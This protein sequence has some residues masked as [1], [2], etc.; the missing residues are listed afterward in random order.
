MATLSS[1]DM[2]SLEQ[3][4][5]VTTLSVTLSTEEIT[6]ITSLVTELNVKLALITQSMAFSKAAFI[7]ITTIEVTEIQ[8]LSGKL[9]GVVDDVVSD[10]IASLM[11]VS[12]FLARI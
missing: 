5:S 4:F 9:D 1:V 11:P 10:S 3:S 7:A 2:N 6:V 8:I 12:A